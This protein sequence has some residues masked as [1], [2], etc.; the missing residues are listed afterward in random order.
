[1]RLARVRELTEPEHEREEVPPPSLKAGETM[2][3]SVQA[4]IDVAWQK[5]V[6]MGL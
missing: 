3:G 5:E 2:V 4:L 6:E 1:M